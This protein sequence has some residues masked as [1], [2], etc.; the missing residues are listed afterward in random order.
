MT[1]LEEIE[2][3]KLEIRD[4]I[5][6]L[7][8]IEKAEELEKEVDALNEEEELINETQNQ[9]EVADALENNDLEAKAKAKEVSIEIKKEGNI[10]ETR[11]TKEY[12]DAYA[13]YIKTGKDEEVRTLLTTNVDGGTIAVPDFVLDEVKT[14]WNNNDLLA[15]VR[16]T[17]VRGN[18]KVNFEISGTDAVIHTEGAYAVNEEELVEG[19]VSITPQSIKKW[20]SVSDEVLD[21]RGESFLR[22]IYDELTYRIAKKCADT[23]VG[24]LATLKQSADAD[25]VSANKITLAPSVD[26]V[27]QAVANLSDEA[28]NP[29]IIMNKLTYADFKKAQY[30]NNYGVDP[31]E[32]LRVVFNNTLPAYSTASAGAVYMIVGDLGHGAIAN[33][34]NGEDIE[35]KLDT[36][37]RKKE[38]LIEV[39]GR[40]Y[41]GLGIVADK[42]FCL[43]AKPESV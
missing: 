25:E 33:F 23:L 19:I 20:V 28:V 9:E 10:M 15:L 1:R 2:E 14:A 6:G 4:E 16:K 8:D 39:L 12:I 26:A 34:P 21:M 3:R 32:G 11:N 36:M 38:D 27:A 41:V 22:Y 35:I 5:D 29:T 40:E 31:F 37:S 24:M 18:L 42:S 30:Q 17:Y 13:E 43:V 7:E